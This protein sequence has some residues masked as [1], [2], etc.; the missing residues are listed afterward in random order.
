MPNKPN[1][2]QSE[3]RPQ[4]PGQGGKMTEISPNPHNE[5]EVTDGAVSTDQAS[6]TQG[7]NVAQSPSTREGRIQ[8]SVA[9][10]TEG[11]VADHDSMF[12]NADP[13]TREV[14]SS[15]KRETRER[16][17]DDRKKHDDAA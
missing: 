17:S 3:D 10:A 16:A 12:N 8:P 14:T 6:E 2:N 13:Q 11:G 7:Q 9:E 1:V 4:S 15:G 5:A